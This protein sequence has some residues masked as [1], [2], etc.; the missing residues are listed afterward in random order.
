M[1]TLCK[2]DTI[3]TAQPSHVVGPFSAVLGRPDE[4]QLPRKHQLRNNWVRER[5]LPPL[6]LSR[7]RLHTSSNEAIRSLSSFEFTS[8][9]C[10]PSLASR[11]SLDARPKTR[12]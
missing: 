7:P 5:G 12:L 3:N 10:G 9:A 11:P 1:S 8:Q 6:D 2:I 4:E